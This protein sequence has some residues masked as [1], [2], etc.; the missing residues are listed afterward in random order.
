[1]KL[2]LRGGQTHEEIDCGANQSI[3]WIGTREKVG[4][5]EIAVVDEV[6]PL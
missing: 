3:G 5:N 1:M 4:H 6:D 2:Q